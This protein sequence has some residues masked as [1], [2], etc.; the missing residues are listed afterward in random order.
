[1]TTNQYTHRNPSYERAFIQA[2]TQPYKHL[3]KE[4]YPKANPIYKN[5]VQYFDSP[6]QGSHLYP[7]MYLIKPVNYD[8]IP[9]NQSVF[10]DK[11]IEENQRFALGPYVIENRIPIM[12]S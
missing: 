10:L 8:Y 9:V 5:P 1:M 7:N 4:V 3:S 11:S 2:E 12:W 6:V